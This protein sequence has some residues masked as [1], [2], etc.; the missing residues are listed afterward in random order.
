MPFLLLFLYMAVDVACGV[1]RVFSSFFFFCFTPIMQ[2][3][4]Q[5]KSFT[6]TTLLYC[7]TPF[8]YYGLTV[9]Y[10][11]TIQAAERNNIENQYNEQVLCIGIY[12]ILPACYMHTTYI[13]PVL[14]PVRNVSKRVLTSQ[15][16][17]FQLLHMRM[18]NIHVD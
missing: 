5:V 11:I 18:H 6:F 2:T 12:C 7:C 10:N 13:L 15:K 16:H 17:S 14:V 8:K 1:W 9:L 4:Q 3:I